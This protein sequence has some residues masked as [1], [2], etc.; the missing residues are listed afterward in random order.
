MR[1]IYLDKRTFHFVASRP[2]NLT[3]KCFKIMMTS[4]EKLAKRTRLLSYTNIR[5]NPTETRSYNKRGAKSV[6]TSSQ[7]TILKSNHTIYVMD[8]FITHVINLVDKCHLSNEYEQW[9][10]WKF[11]AQTDEN[12]M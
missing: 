1:N 2:F 6:V 7:F 11:T 12:S 9:K 8:M 5:E 4:V 3:K 10:N